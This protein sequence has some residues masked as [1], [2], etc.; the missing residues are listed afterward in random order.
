MPEGL[1][2]CSKNAL[3]RSDCRLGCI[4]IKHEHALPRHF[5]RFGL[6]RYLLLHLH[7][8]LLH[9]LSVLP[10]LVKVICAL[11]VW[12]GFLPAYHLKL[13]VWFSRRQLLNHGLRWNKTFWFFS[14]LLSKR[15]KSLILLD[16]LLL[17]RFNSR[18]H[19]NWLQLIAR[20]EHIKIRSVLSYALRITDYLKS[21]W[22][23]DQAIYTQKRVVARLLIF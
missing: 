13:S 20:W 21:T 4:V 6:D 7:L 10:D 17:P 14:L 15:V 19:V 18:W 5:D 11:S 9:S 2:G 23:R 1:A 3:L 8:H 16:R 12:H 22:C